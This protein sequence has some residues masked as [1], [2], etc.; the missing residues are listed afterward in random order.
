[1]VYHPREHVEQKL[2]R[3]HELTE[4][5]KSRS[6]TVGG[7]P[8]PVRGLLE[9]IE[10]DP[11]GWVLVTVRRRDGRTGTVTL[12]PDTSIIIH[13]DQQGKEHKSMPPPR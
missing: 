6:I 3:A 8:W 10:R 13:R 5:H 11:R 7:Q 1:M 9:G 2:F 4:Q 12:P